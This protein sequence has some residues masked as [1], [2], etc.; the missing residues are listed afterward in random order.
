MLGGCY[1]EEDMLEICLVLLMLVLGYVSKVILRLV[2]SLWLLDLKEK[3]EKVFVCFR[4]DFF[5]EKV[6]KMFYVV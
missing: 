3:E 4:G 5:F 2:N 6:L 1:E